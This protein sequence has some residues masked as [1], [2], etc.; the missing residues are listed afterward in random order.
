LYNN[1]LLKPDPTLSNIPFFSFQRSNNITI[2]GISG[3]V[4]QNTPLWSFEQ[5]TN[6]TVTNTN[7]GITGSIIDARDSA[8]IYITNNVFDKAMNALY[9]KNC[10]NVVVS[11]N[12]FYNNGYMIDVS[13]R[14]G[15]DSAPITG[16]L[17]FTSSTGITVDNNYFWNCSYAVY[18][19]SG[20]VAMI[21]N[22]FFNSTNDR[23]MFNSN[24]QPEVTSV[25]I[26]WPSTI[27]CPKVS[28][29][30]WGSFQGN[31]FCATVQNGTFS[32]SCGIP[33]PSY[34]SFFDQCQT[35]A[36]KSVYSCDGS[37]F[38]DDVTCPDSR[39]L[40]VSPNATTN[41]DGS[42]SNPFASIRDAMDVAVWKDEIR[43][44]AGNYFGARNQGRLLNMINNQNKPFVGSIVAEG[45]D[46]PL[47]NNV[48]I[49]C[50]QLPR[51]ETFTPSYVFIDA[52]TN[53]PVT[54][55]V[56][57]MRF[58][59]CGQVIAFSHT[60]YGG[61]TIEN[62]MFEAVNASMVNWQGLVYGVYDWYMQV[63]IRNSQI[64]DIVTIDWHTDFDNNAIGPI[65]SYQ[66]SGLYP[67]IIQTYTVQTRQTWGKPSPFPTY[68]I[69]RIENVTMFNVSV[70]GL[71][72]LHGGS[73]QDA[74]LV[75]VLF[76]GGENREAPIM[77]TGTAV[78]SINV[79]N[80]I[81]APVSKNYCFD[82]LCY[83]P[84]YDVIASCASSG[85]TPDINGARI[86]HSWFENMK[87][88]SSYL[89]VG[90]N[91][92]GGRAASVNKLP[93][94]TFPALFNNTSS[95]GRNVNVY[96]VTTVKKS[97]CLVPENLELPSAISARLN[98]EGLDCNGD[99]FG[100]RINGRSGG[101]CYAEQTTTS[102]NCFADPLIV[103][104]GESSTAGGDNNSTISPTDISVTTDSNGGGKTS[105]SGNVL[106]IAWLL[107]AVYIAAV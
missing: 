94:L 53:V 66:S 93:Y 4:N 90:T 10:T 2:S 75:D 37:C 91:C 79:T 28:N 71:F 12:K 73:F 85:I 101:C 68:S 18:V 14:A 43:L 100:T 19:D 83:G 24:H 77:H 41:G 99:C 80:F 36:P 97:S 21:N 70:Q 81:Y 106:C 104:T 107:V 60:G 57:G 32:S 26:A 17:Y 51:D 16:A 25:P 8:G 69:A 58:Y 74:T 62:I 3:D 46:N 72:V 35:C 29:I 92:H 6:C 5:S 82:D 1:T 13:Q 98:K 49:D 95:Y 34:T 87:V 55:T 45:G 54:F 42:R 76:V 27:V 33:M 23:F 52:K 84:Y 88:Y 15:Y 48:T 20:L 44:L 38:R 31:G 65:Y 39:V 67:A 7:F 63:V 61:V 11:S 103:S 50:T 47:N 102:G 78:S 64:K 86:T 9:T 89:P 22:S 96:N 40:Y 30:Q 59:G 56:R 105:S